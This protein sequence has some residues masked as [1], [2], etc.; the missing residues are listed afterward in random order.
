MC[1]FKILTFHLMQHWLTV[2]NYFKRHHIRVIHLVRRNKLRRVISRQSAAQVAA[3]NRA[4]N[5][6]IRVDAAYHPHSPEELAA[7]RSRR[8]RL[9]S[10]SLQS[11]FAIELMQDWRVAHTF[12]VDRG[13]TTTSYHDR[14]GV[15]QLQLYYE[16]AIANEQFTLRL[17]QQFIGVA[18][19][20][21]L[22]TEISNVLGHASLDSLLVNVDDVRQALHN[23]Q[24][25]NLLCL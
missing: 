15:Q 10:A 21:T 9:G 18:T 20:R 16:D 14:M 5:A 22:H 3:Y 7:V 19:L 25:K 24:F 8:V 6:S 4:R 17:V 23:T 2:R 1:S 12:N 13:N 11:E